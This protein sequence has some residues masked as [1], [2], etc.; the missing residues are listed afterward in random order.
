MK[1]PVSLTA[2]IS[3][4]FA[5]SAAC[6]LLTAGLLFER[7]GEN[8]FQ[9]HYRMELDGKME[10]VRNALGSI[11]SPVSLDALRMRLRD[12]IVTSHPGIAITVTAGDGTMLFSVGQAE[13]VKRLLEGAEIGKPQPVT[14]TFG[15]HTYNIATERI[16]FGIPASQPVNVAIALDITSDQEFSAEFMKFLWFGM[17]LTTL[18]MGWLGWVAVR[19]GLS[20]LHDVSAMVANVSAQQL[21]KPLPAECVP[22]ELEEL[23]SAF[24]RMLAQLHDSFRRLSEFSADIAHELRTPINSMMMQT[25]VTLSRERDSGEYHANL[26]SNLEEL[27]RLSRMI[28]DM[29]FLATVDNSLIAPKREVID[30]QAEVAKLFDFYEA[31]AGESH[32]RMVQNGAATVCADRLMIQRALS[33]LL[34]NAIRFT[35]EGMAVEVTI[36]ENA[37]QAMIAVANPG[38][39]I[40]AEHLPR[41]FERL[42]RVDAARRE[43]HAENVGLGLAITQS[44]IEMHGGT[45]G[46]ESAKGR[47]CFTITLPGG[48]CSE[49][50]LRHSSYHT[51]SAFHDQGQNS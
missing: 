30:L 25:Q 32:V 19:R 28:S 10:L 7:V 35:P 3:L 13:V 14:W 42:Y 4:L 31:L 47:T 36:G 5:G 46:A 29:L 2:R 26:Q 6:V 23:V 34:S 1:K 24:N 22:R 12:T 38:P 9:K 49:N 18:A 39:E 50:H 48:Q 21:D 44:I 16:A 33:N 11:T 8:Q 40:P 15:N 27:E 51:S 41:I 43:G 45:I 17:A 37:N 20:P